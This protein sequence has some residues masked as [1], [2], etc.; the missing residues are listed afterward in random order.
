MN[1]EEELI[2]RWIDGELDS[3]AQA[4]FD[5]LMSDDPKF[6][7]RAKAAAESLG[8]ALRSSMAADVDPSYPDFFN[9]QI[10]KRIRE[11]AAVAS[12]VF[13]GGKV[14]VLSWLRSPFTMSAAAAACAVFAGLLITRGGGESLGGGS[15]VVSTYAPDPMVSVVRAEFDESAGATV[16]MLTGLQRIPDDVEVGGKDIATYEPAGPRGFGRF[17]TRDA[18]LAYILETDADGAPNFLTR[19][20]S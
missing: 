18:E 7:A 10:Q 1:R 9:S 4:E 6:P 15:Q 11:E 2:T 20:G 16:I 19:S 17:Y 12:A 13:G 14:S 3:A 8:D 5:K